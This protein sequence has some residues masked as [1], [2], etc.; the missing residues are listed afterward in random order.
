[1]EVAAIICWKTMPA[2]PEEDLELLR[3]S[4]MAFWF[5]CGQ[6]AKQIANPSD[7]GF[8]EIYWWILR[9]VMCRFFGKRPA[10]SVCK[11]SIKI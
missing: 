10:K 2:D 9:S 6:V 11:N 3:Q 4:A 8:Y 1:M 5:A 7:G